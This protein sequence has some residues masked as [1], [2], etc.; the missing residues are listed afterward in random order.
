[1]KHL[2]FACKLP[3]FGAG[4]SK[5]I[6]AQHNPTGPTHRSISLAK[7][8]ASSWMCG[9]GR[10]VTTW[11]GVIAAEALKDLHGD[12]PAL[13]GRL[14]VVSVLHSKSVLYGVRMD[15]RGA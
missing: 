5:R 13:P 4:I 9:P 2:C 8:T 12:G 7:A 15:A 6:V 14:S 11:G 10:Q 3:K 1:M